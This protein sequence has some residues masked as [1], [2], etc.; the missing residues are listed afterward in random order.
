MRTSPT[1]GSFGHCEC[2]PSSMVM[3][4]VSPKVTP[5]RTTV[6][7]GRGFGLFMAPS[8]CAGPILHG[9]G[10]EGAWR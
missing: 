4:L 3:E 9:S 2:S 10:G 5:Q 7:G 8:C 6:L 1:N